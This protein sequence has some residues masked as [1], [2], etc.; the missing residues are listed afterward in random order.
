[1]LVMR[2]RDFSKQI[3]AIEQAIHREISEHPLTTQPRA[4]KDWNELRSTVR[5]AA[6]DLILC[7]DVDEAI[8]RLRQDPEAWSAVA[9]LTIEAPVSQDDHRLAARR[10]FEATIHEPTVLPFHAFCSYLIE[11]CNGLEIAP[12]SS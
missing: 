7:A 4:P 11:L 5:R 3:F 10:A 12:P 2:L 6:E 8:S 1:M 9:W